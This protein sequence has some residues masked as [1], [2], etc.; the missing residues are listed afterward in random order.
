MKIIHLYWSLASQKA[1]HFLQLP[2]TQIIQ[3]ILSTLVF[4]SGNK[5]LIERPGLDLK[6]QVNPHGFVRKVHDLATK[7]VPVF[8]I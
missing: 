5:Y 2:Q 7:I 6:N 8:L 4:E 3:Y 1:L